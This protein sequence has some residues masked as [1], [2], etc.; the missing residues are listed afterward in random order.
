MMKK[1]RLLTLALSC[2]CVFTSAAAVGIWSL[3]TENANA[4]VYEY[5]EY[6]VAQNDDFG[7]ATTL[8]WPNGNATSGLKLNN[9]LPTASFVYKF[10]YTPNDGGQT[11]LALRSS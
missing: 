6:V 2:A 5:E 4:V 9:D 10:N 3:D 7:A 8:S 11:A 1:Q